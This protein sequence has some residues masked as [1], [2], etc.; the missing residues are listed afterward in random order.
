MET[1]LRQERDCPE[2]EGILVV[3]RATR[4]YYTFAQFKLVFHF[5]MG[6][7]CV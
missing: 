7:N 1:Q 6:M 5:F 3:I 2:M 4:G